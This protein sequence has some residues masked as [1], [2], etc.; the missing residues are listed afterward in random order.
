MQPLTILLNIILFDCVFTFEND[1]LLPLFVHFLWLSELHMSRISYPL[2]LNASLVQ[3]CGPIIRILFNGLELFLIINIVVNLNI[4][5]TLNVQGVRAVEIIN[6]FPML[7]IDDSWLETQ[8][9]TRTIL[10]DTK[11][12]QDLIAKRVFIEVQSNGLFK[13]IELLPIKCDIVIYQLY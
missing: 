2:D 6:F 12:A 5:G 9:F 7:F 10:L 3:S 8:C 4:F 11:M 13:T 1:E